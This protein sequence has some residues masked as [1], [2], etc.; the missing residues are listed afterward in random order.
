MR[1]AARG[2]V[3]LVSCDFRVVVILWLVLSVLEGSDVASN[4]FGTSLASFGDLQSSSILVSEEGRREGG[5]GTRVHVSSDSEGSGRIVDSDLDRSARYHQL[6]QESTAGQR[7]TYESL[8]LLD[9]DGYR[10]VES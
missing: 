5:K 3:D 7:C 1:E 8:P 2:A 10:F 9:S 4:E 6:Q